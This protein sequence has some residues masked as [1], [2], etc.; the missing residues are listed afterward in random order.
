[1]RSQA[2]K[3]RDP[4]V[5]HMSRFPRPVSYTQAVYEDPFGPTKS[6]AACEMGACTRGRTGLHRGSTH[7]PAGS[8]QLHVRA[9]PPSAA[10]HLFPLNFAGGKYAVHEQRDR[11]RAIGAADALTRRCR[12]EPERITLGKAD[13][14]LALSKHPLNLCWWVEP[15]RRH[16]ATRGVRAREGSISECSL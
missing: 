7:T 5:P 15:I 12:D 1:M 13:S 2:T 10:A 3:G 8:H 14:Q 4:L 16:E 6:Q 11:S 9:T